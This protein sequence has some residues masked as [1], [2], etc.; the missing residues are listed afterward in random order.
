MNLDLYNETYDFIC[1]SI[2]KKNAKLLEIGCGPGN[3][4][5]YLL[6][7]RPDF[8]IQGID[9]APNMIALAKKNN[10]L[11]SFC[12]MDIRHIDKLQTKFDGI[13]GGFCLP[14]LSASE[15]L[16]LITDSCDLLIDNGLLYIS[17]V[18]GDPKMSGFQVGSSGDRSY[19]NYHTLENL[20]RLLINNGFDQ[21][22]LFKVNY[23]QADNKKIFHTILVTRKK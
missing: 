2:L 17:F 16:K 14:Y 8:K 6:T 3:I 7:K 10:P 13:I 18:E 21:P 20:N 22:E 1:N 11:A 23:P 4:T 19:F 9:I 12:V 5:K 15:S